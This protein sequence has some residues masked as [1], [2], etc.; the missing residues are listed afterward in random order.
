MHELFGKIGPVGGRG[1][2]RVMYDADAPT[3][4]PVAHSGANSRH[5]RLE[6]APLLQA[7]LHCGSKESWIYHTRYVTKVHIVL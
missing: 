3:L 1:S 2:V 6:P 4:K 5:V 7:A